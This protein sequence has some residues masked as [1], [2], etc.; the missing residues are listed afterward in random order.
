MLP[1]VFVSLRCN[2]DALM[3][4]RAVPV[5]GLCSAATHT[6]KHTRTH[7]PQQLRPTVCFKVNSPLPLP[8]WAH[9]ALLAVGI[10]PGRGCVCLLLL[11]LIV[12]ISKVVLGRCRFTGVE[13][14]GVHWGL[15]VDGA[16]RPSSRK[17]LS[18]I[19]PHRMF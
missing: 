14:A 7:T 4:R 15:G 16:D 17:R 10:P 9:S 18:I 12:L 13:T 3:E 5:Q 2:F 11:P 19:S 1:C 8:R 6:S